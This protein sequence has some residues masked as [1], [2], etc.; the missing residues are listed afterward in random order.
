MHNDLPAAVA[1][2]QPCKTCEMLQQTV[3]MLSGKIRRLELLRRLPDIV[4]GLR[5]DDIDSLVLLAQ[6][7]IENSQ[8]TRARVS[9]QAG[10]QPVQPAAGGVE[11]SKPELFGR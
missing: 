9:P 7:L 4:C 1:S 10:T 5:G 6:A 2:P 3:I 8:E 11:G